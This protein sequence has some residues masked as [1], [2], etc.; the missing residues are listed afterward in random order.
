MKLPED[1]D[2]ELWFTV[3]D[4]CHGEKHYLLG[5]P[6]TFKGRIMAWCPHK[7]TSF[8]VSLKEMKE[9]SEPARWWITGYLRGN[10][11]HPPIN[12]DGDTNFDSKEYKAWEKACD[13]FHESGVWK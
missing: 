8:F 3:P 4:K 1:I 11:P 7:E 9:L 6:H 2:K 5:N 10:E 13:E 12:G